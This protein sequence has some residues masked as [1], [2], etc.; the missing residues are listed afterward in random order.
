MRGK[1]YVAE[2]RL[3]GWDKFKKMLFKFVLSALLVSLLAALYF[4]RG[5]N[6]YL[7]N[8][9]RVSIFLKDDVS[10][11]VGSLF[12]NKLERL[13]FVRK[14]VYHNQEE[15]WKEFLSAVEGKE[16]LKELIGRPIPGYIEVWFSKEGLSELNL[17]RLLGICEDEGIVKDVIY[18]EDSFR[19]VMRLKRYLN[20]TFYTL[21]VLLVIGVASV[22]YFLDAS[23]L[24]SM[25]GEM[26]FA[27]IHDAG[28]LDF[29]PW[30]FFGRLFEGLVTG[31]LSYSLFFLVLTK[32][33]TVHPSIAV[34]LGMPASLT[35]GDHA[36]SLFLSVLLVA[37]IFVTSSFI[38]LKRVR[39]ALE[40][41]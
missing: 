24:V 8:A 13:S 26:R 14:A 11:E 41:S 1:V 39:E 40:V 18:G 5:L 37:G 12:A 19:R 4:S 27:A 25:A 20:L 23:L 3:A 30:M 29:F 34:F 21:Y 10:E 32:V 2:W 7:S 33:K 9:W 31:F 16:D 28:F 38:S 15:V 17:K 35:Y 22:F 6:A 36:A